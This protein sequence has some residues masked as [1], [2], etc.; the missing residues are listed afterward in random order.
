[1]YTVT[2]LTM[3]C[4]LAECLSVCVDT[5]TFFAVCDTFAWLTVYHCFP[6]NDMVR[7]S[8]QERMRRDRMYGCAGH[9]LEPSKLQQHRAL[10][11]VP[12]VQQSAF[13]TRV[14]CAAC[15]ID[16]SNDSIH[17]RM[18][19]GLSRDLQTGQGSTHLES[20]LEELWEAARGLGYSLKINTVVCR[21]VGRHVCQE[22]FRLLANW[23][24]ITLY[25]H[26]CNMSITRA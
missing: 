10:F 12:V 11:A 18:G 5:T 24:T 23:V 4:K 15:Q 1:M 17:T 13:L 26:L 25:A 3:P 22:R 7:C 2:L 9:K 14:Y 20:G 16:A 19:R 8:I 6:H 21:C